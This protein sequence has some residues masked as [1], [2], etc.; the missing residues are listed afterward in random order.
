[1]AEIGQIKK[2]SELGFKDKTHKYIWL[3]C[4]HCGKGKWTRI[5]KGQPS[6]DATKQ[7]RCNAVRSHTNGRL[8]VILDRGYVCIKLEASDFFYPM[9]TRYGWLREHRLVMARALG[10]LLQHWEVVHH[11]NGIKSDN[12]LDNLE[13]TLNGQHMTDHSK[14]YIHGFEKGYQDG[15][16]KGRALSFHQVVKLR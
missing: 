15:L 16:A 3:L 11:K 14:G 7:C 10:R 5:E 13:L 1:M 2:A 12:R 9:A 4:P 8:G 6:T